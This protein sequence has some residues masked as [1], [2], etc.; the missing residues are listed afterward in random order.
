MKTRRIIVEVICFVLLMFWFYEGVYKVAYL[1]D[2]G[3]YMMRAPLLRPLGSILK[4]VVPFAEI[5]LTAFFIV[6]RF[7]RVALYGTISF[8]LLYIFWVMGMTFF[9]HSLFWPYHALWKE[10]TWLQKI[11]ITSGL[12][13]MAFL[14]VVLPGLDFQ[15]N[16]MNRSSLR[17]KPANA[18]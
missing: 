12:G 14:A 6:P 9:T 1:D 10:P 2:F 3:L 8:S 16:K 13:W 7:R 11:L 4:Y 18:S 5:G 17:N 15:K